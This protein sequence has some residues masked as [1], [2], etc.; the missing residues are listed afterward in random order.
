MITKEKSPMH[1]LFFRDHE[2]GGYM[3]TSSTGNLRRNEDGD[4]L[5]DQLVCV[6]PRPNLSDPVNY[7]SLN[8][9]LPAPPYEAPPGT[10]EVEP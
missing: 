4:L 8:Y 1:A 5:G 6:Y 10:Q 7:M 9:P 2:T 3:V